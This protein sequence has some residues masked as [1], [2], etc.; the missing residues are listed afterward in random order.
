MDMV[1]VTEDMEDTMEDTEDMTEDM[2]D[3]EAIT[4]DMETME[5]TM[6]LVPHSTDLPVSVTVTS[7]V[8]FFL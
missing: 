4:T 5:A 2:E 6:A 3:M 7:T 8:S 1:D